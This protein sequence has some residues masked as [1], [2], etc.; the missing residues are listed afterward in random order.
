VRR[1]VAGRLP[2]RPHCPGPGESRAMGPCPPLGNSKGLHALHDGRLTICSPR[3]VVCGHRREG[4]DPPSRGPRGG[5]WPAR[6]A[7]RAGS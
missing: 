2:R 3:A 4:R 5:C 1:M 7:A 6:P